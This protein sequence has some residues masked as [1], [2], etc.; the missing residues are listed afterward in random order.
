MAINDP[1]MD[2][3]YLLYLLNYDSVHGTR[4]PHANVLCI[5]PPHA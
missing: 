3:D 5:S 4:P 2:D 1:F